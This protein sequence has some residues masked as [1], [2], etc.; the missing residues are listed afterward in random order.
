MVKFI[1]P[2][3][4]RHQLFRVSFEHRIAGNHTAWVLRRHVI[5][6]DRAI[7]KGRVITNFLAALVAVLEIYAGVLLLCTTW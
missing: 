6:G 4:Y 1:N 2:P 3:L 5:K 7:I